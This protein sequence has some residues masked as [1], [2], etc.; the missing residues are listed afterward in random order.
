MLGTSCMMPTKTRNNQS[1]YLN[2]AGYGVMFDCG[3]GTQRQMI[4]AGIKKSN[5]DYILISHFHGDHVGGLL[6]L[7]QSMGNEAGD[8]K[9]E[10]HGPKGTKERLEWAFKFVDFETRLNLE[11]FE[12]DAKDLL[13]IVDTSFFRIQC[14]NLEH[15]I[16]CLGFSFVEK[17]KRKLNVGFME[18]KGMK[19]GPYLKDLQN[20]NDIEFNGELIKSE[21]ATYL[22]KGKKVTYITDTRYCD[23]CITLSKNS[24]LLISESTLHSDDKE[25]AIQSNHMTARDAAYIAKQ[26]DVEKLLLTHFSRRYKDPEVLKEDAKYYFDN[27]ELAEDFLDLLI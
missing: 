13:T 1:V 20:G 5:I 19:S 6:P 17:D 18:E 25:K 12:Y 10:L 14:I 3:E 8:K 2:Y 27:V 22:V 26:A 21:D 23:N 15:G 7:L 9:V 16:P 11:I 24:E 4:Q